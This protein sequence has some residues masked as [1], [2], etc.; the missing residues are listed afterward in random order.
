MSWD[1]SGSLWVVEMVDYSEQENDALGRL[2]KLIDSDNDGVMDQAQVVAEGL[3]WPTALATLENRTWVAA[4]P[5][6]R[7]FKSN[8]N[9]PKAA[10]T[11][12]TILDGLGRQNVQ[13]LANSFHWGLYRLVPTEGT[14]YPR[15]LNDCSCR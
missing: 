2:S 6:L 3:S 5:I 14:W 7:E 8:E 11:S 10:W 4:A 12:T 9:D 13:G 1:A 15:H